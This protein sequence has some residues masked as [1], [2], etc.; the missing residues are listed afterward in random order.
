[1]GETQLSEPASRSRPYA[2]VGQHSIGLA[3]AHAERQQASPRTTPSTNFCV[4]PQ[5]S[6]FWAWPHAPHRQSAP[7]NGAARLPS[8]GIVRRIIA[9]F[10]SWRQCDRSWSDL[11]DLNDTVLKD[12]GLCREDFGRSC[13]QPHRYTD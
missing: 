9:A 10:R 5:G 1:M 7:S 8:V 6:T 3:P 2:R 11:R 13:I 4:V 12:I